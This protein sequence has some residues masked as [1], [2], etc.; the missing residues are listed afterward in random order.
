MWHEPRQL[1]W[2]QRHQM[3]PHSLNM[4][5]TTHT[6][7][8]TSE[9]QPTLPTSHNVNVTHVSSHDTAPPAAIA[10]YAI[11]STPRPQGNGSPSHAAQHLSCRQSY[12]LHRSAQHGHTI[13]R[14]WPLHHFTPHCMLFMRHCCHHTHRTP[15][16]V[17]NW[18]TRIA[19]P[20][21]R[22]RRCLKDTNVH[23]AITTETTTHTHTPRQ[24]PHVS[25]THD[26][27]SGQHA[28][29]TTCTHKTKK[30]KKE[31]SVPPMSKHC[32]CS[33]GAA[34]T[35][36]CTASVPNRRFPAQNEHITWSAH[37]PHTHCT[38]LKPKLHARMCSHVHIHGHAHSQTQHTC[39]APQTLSSSSCGQWGSTRANACPS[40]GVKWQPVRT[41][42]SGSHHNS[43]HN[44]TPAVQ[45][46]ARYPS[47]AKQKATRQIP[48]VTQP[49]TE[50]MQHCQ[51][52]TRS[53]TSCQYMQAR[54]QPE[55]CAR[56]HPHTHTHTQPPMSETA[57][58]TKPPRCSPTHADTHALMEA[59]TTFTTLPCAA[60]HAPALATSTSA[61]APC[62]AS[63]R[64]L[65][66]KPL[67]VSSCLLSVI[68][69]PTH[70]PSG[71]P[72]G[73]SSLSCPA[74]SDVPSI[75]TAHS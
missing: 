3:S 70:S 55:L 11:R 65:T 34:L 75:A 63:A 16:A 5:H 57:L 17:S 6:C 38:R 40:A 66:T 52:C 21:A 46:A 25:R 24:T 37:A 69:L 41:C 73:P 50:Q 49:R 13:N 72:T 51:C 39:C 59:E 23:T 62:C 68:C 27:G 28:C 42:A 31:V 12:S 47:E 1:Q 20:A 58:R 26:W 22:S 15:V 36:A 74:A 64:T 61:A 54:T 32:M 67:L 4:G 8:C 10:T 29:G 35:I 60:S 71:S 2:P 56:T 53:E 45:E 19:A 7:A 30:Q 33:R 18:A 48:A 43:M 44:T 14:W 9:K